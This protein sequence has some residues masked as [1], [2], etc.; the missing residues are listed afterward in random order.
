MAA[1]I[2]VSGQTCKFLVSIEEQTTVEILV[3]GS[4]LS[5]VKQKCYQSFSSRAFSATLTMLL[6][7]ALVRAKKV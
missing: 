1:V 3:Y 6:T 5:L 4:F 2:F 7:E